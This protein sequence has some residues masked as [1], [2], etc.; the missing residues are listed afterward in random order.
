MYHAFE[1]GISCEDDKSCVS[2]GT[3]ILRIEAAGDKDLVMLLT[4]FPANI[5]RGFVSIKFVN[6]LTV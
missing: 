3:V 1:L 5:V 6:L 4:D 2:T